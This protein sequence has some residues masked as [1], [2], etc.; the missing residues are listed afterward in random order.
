MWKWVPLFRLILL[1]SGP[2]IM[3]ESLI[4]FQKTRLKVCLL[5][6]LWILETQ[7]S[8]L[9]GFLAENL[10][11]STKCKFEENLNN[12]TKAGEFW[13]MK[14]WKENKIE[15]QG[16]HSPIPFPSQTFKKIIQEISWFWPTGSSKDFGS[17]LG[18]SVKWILIGGYSPKE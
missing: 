8:L 2:F 13:Q 4:T 7:K 12:L 17:N 6:F 9:R 3:L 11:E 16:Q 14:N 5:S 1:E 18:E 15:Y 10:V